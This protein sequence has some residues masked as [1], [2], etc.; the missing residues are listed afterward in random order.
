MPRTSIPGYWLLMAAN[1]RRQALLQWVAEH[2]DRWLF[3]LL[4]VGLAVLL[5]IWISLF[6]LV[7]VVAAHGVLEWLA[8]RLRGLPEPGLG[9]VLWHIKLDIVLILFALWL[10]LYLETLFGLA[11]LGALARTGAQAGA[12]FVAW[13]RALRGALMT[14]DDAAQ[15]ARAV[16][17]RRNGGK[18]TEPAPDGHGP[19]WTRGDRITIAFGALFVGLILLAP[20]VTE[21]DATSALAAIALDLHPWP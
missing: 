14:L 15:V 18:S 10:G 12:R 21:H 1:T 2:D 6:W 8:M 19:G 13:Q 11:G 17:A 16:A 4:Y 3:T 7:V 5:S 20:W 9:E